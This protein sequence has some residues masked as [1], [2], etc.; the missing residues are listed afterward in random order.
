MEMSSEVRALIEELLRKISVLEQEVA[1]L[2]RQLG[3]DSSNSSKP[4][5]SDGLGKKPLRTSSL[6]GKSGKVSGGQAG[7]K[8]GTL[9]QVA[10]PDVIVQHTAS[11]CAHCRAAL[12]AAMLTGVVTRQVFDVPEPRLEV[13]EHRAQVYCCAA[14]R[15][16]TK[17]CFPA[18]VV[19]PVQYGPGVRG[20]AIYL[21]VQHLIPED[22]VAEIL[23]ELAGARGLCPA[24][25]TSWVTQ[26]AAEWAP[27]A[28][29]IGALLAAAPV[30]HLDET[31][32]RVAGK[33]QWLHSM[34]TTALTHYRVSPKRG[35]V[36]DD[37]AGGIVVHDHFKPYFKLAGLSH[38]LCNAHHLRELKALAEIDGEA[39]AAVM[40][41][42]LCDTNAEVERAVEQGADC[43]P[44]GTL[45]KITAAYD[46]IVT[47]G[48]VFH[49]SQPALARK[50]GA[51]RGKP[52]KRPGHNL[53][54]RL[55]DFKADVLRFAANF[56]VPFTNNQAERDIR[57]MKLKMKIAGSFR[58]Q[59]AA[60]TFAILRS[61]L[62]TLKKQAKNQLQAL[63]L[64]DLIIT[65]ALTA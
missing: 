59:A 43:L 25:I 11:A 58:T 33:T 52:P 4:P 54:I 48:L 21:N 64:S 6:R 30:R 19:S 5:S 26:K 31:G 63:S 57:M 10:A 28:E 14:C 37:L 29:H 7:H 3:R 1:D 50:P 15:G 49:D 55:R 34:S 65:Q 45:D 61:V 22:R 35:A 42:F 62:S 51:R 16:V 53:L 9:R 38:A 2:R 20:W 56:A 24:S 18:G 39:W 40:S 41:R 32:F 12:S 27:V 36:P 46:K 8:G 60:N 47:E 44:A 23:A 13:T 17:A